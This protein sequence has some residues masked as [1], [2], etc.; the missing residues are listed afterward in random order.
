M[1][2]QNVCTSGDQEWT[3]D[4]PPLELR[5]AKMQLLTIGKVA[6]MGLWKGGLGQYF[7]A[8]APLLRIPKDVVIPPTVYNDT[9]KKEPE[10][11]E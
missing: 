7:V 10:D 5:G 9:R 4:V 6:V 8:Y 11:G 3:F 1:S 2:Q